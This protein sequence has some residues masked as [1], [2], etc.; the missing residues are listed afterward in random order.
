MGFKR[1]DI[2]ESFDLAY[3]LLHPI[4]RK[5]VEKMMRGNSPIHIAQ[6]AKEFEI[7]EKL[8]SFHLASMLQYGLVKGEW[9][10]A[11]EPGGERRAVKYYSLTNKTEEVFEDIKKW[12]KE[13]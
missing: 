8:A 6:V 9:G 13:T 12:L 2:E 5:I 10:T 4:R 3:V 11:I 7:D 1:E